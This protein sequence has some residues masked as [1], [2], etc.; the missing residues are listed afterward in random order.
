MVIFLLMSYSV[1]PTFLLQWFE[2]MFDHMARDGHETQW[3]TLCES[4]QPELQQLPEKM[5][6]QLTGLQRMLI[7]RAVRSDRLLHLAS[8]FITSVLGKRWL[9]TSTLLSIYPF[10]SS[11]IH[12]AIHPFIHLSIY[13][14]IHQFI[15][16]YS[17]S[18][19]RPSVN[20]SI[21]SFLLPFIHPFTHPS[22]DLSM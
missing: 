15:H 11:F 9:T 17:H 21:H 4:E 13:S 8:L 2:E 12:I 7:I 18:S 20:S 6:D 10:I 19:V 5:D 1:S 14:P 3:R 22:V 16:P